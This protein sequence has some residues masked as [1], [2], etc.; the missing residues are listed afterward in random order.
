MRL[1][2]LSF[3]ITSSDFH[4]NA[5]TPPPPILSSIKIK[6]KCCIETC[7]LYKVS[8]HRHKQ[9]R[10]SKTV[11]GN[12]ILLRP[13]LEFKDSFLFYW[14]K[15]RFRKQRSD[16]STDKNR[17]IIASAIYQGVGPVAQRLVTG[18]TVRGSNHGGGE[19]FRTCPD[20]PWGPPSLLCNGHR[21][22]LGGEERTGRDAD[23]SPL[24]VLWTRKSIAIPLLT[25]WAVRPVHSLSACTVELYLYSLFGPYGLYTTSVP[26][27]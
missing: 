2:H 16:I 8:W 1:Y 20:R 6:Q 3:D 27:Q 13:F 10:T 25:L 24:L 12:W 17:Q 22:F 14:T 19:I 5:P 9:C 23:P 26:V 7:C 4:L 15:E 18:W 21:V 11:N